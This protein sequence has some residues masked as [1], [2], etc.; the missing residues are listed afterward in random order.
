MML[1]RAKMLTA[2]AAGLIGVIFLLP[3]AFNVK[4]QSR[5]GRLSWP[6]KEGAY[7][8]TSSA[9][10]PAFPRKWSGYRRDSKSDGTLRVFEGQGWQTID[11]LSPQQSGCSG[12][13]FMFRWRVGNPNVRVVT[14]IGYSTD[15]IYKRARAGS[16]GYIYGTFCEQ[17]MFRFA[18]NARDDGSNSVD[19]YY[20]VEWWRAAP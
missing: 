18:D 9:T 15:N 1:Q 2:L 13:V 16:Y 12:G 5:K 4:G 11:E 8:A 20:E 10:I 17:P 6:K 19:I 3:V 7:T 14:A